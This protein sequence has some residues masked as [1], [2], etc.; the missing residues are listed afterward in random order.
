MAEDITQLK[1]S[2]S[3]QRETVDI[4]EAKV[5]KQAQLIKDSSN[6]EDADLTTQVE[7]LQG[8]LQILKG[9]YVTLDT[10]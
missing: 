2:V 1:L 6:D 5:T 9:E 4:H 8:T 7:E 3:T 10:A